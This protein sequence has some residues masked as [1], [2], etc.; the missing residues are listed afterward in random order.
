MLLSLLQNPAHDQ[1]CKRGGKY[2]VRVYVPK[3]LQDTLR[4]QQVWR[5]TGTGDLAEAK[6]RAPRIHAQILDELEAEHEAMLHGSDSPRSPA[7]LF[8]VAAELLEQVE[9]GEWTSADASSVLSDYRDEFLRL[10]SESN[11][12]VALASARSS[13]AYLESRGTILP[14]SVAAER[15]LAHLESQGRPRSTIERKQMVI[16]RFAKFVGDP[17]VS[18]V[19]RKVAGRWVEEDLNRSSLKPKTKVWYLSALQ[20]AWTYFMLRGFADHNPFEK[21]SALVQGD[22]RGTEDTDKSR[23][24]TQ[25]ELDKLKAVDKADPLYTVSVIRLHSGIRVEE[26]CCLRMKDIDLDANT[27]RIAG[28]T[29]NQQSQRVLWMHS[30]VQ[31]LMPKLLE[32]AN[33]DGYLFDLEPAGRD[34][35]RSHNLS[36]RVNR[37][38]RR[39]VSEDRGVTFYTLRHTYSQALRDLGVDKETIEYT[40]GHKDQSMLFGTYAREVAVA[41]L[42]EVVEK[43][44][45]G[46]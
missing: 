14:L 23:A 6:R 38:I 19:D 18:D 32:N 9:S 39:N 37:W 26:A 21:M 45:F 7:H 16:Q 28:N 10:N 4:R 43:L 29:K 34:L 35:K 33:E 30:V 44:D 22:K 17:S 41:R 31:K 46:F 20:A 2:S 12:R 3:D 36:K 13:T 27:M 40:T 8:A 5:T 25:E 1:P 42:R 11:A 15:H 24:W